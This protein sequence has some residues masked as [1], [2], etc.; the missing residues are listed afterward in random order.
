MEQL[1]DV[2]VINA[3]I[4]DNMIGGIEF[5]QTKDTMDGTA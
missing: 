2:R 3:K 4:S 5:S 1:G